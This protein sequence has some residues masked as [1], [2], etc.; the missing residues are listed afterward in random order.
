[1]SPPYP[2]L[3]GLRGTIGQGKAY[4]FFS[5]LLR[6]LS[7]TWKYKQSFWEGGSESVLH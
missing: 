2:G 7:Q 4:V 6:S 5:F 1:M 3:L